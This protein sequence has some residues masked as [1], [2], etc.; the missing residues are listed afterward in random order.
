[1][2][3][4]LI[5]GATSAIAQETARVW[6]EQGHTL[7]LVGRSP[8]KLEAV[9]QDLRV[10]GATVHSRV[11]DLDKIEDHASLI[12]WAFEILIQVDTALIAHGAMP[13]Q[14]R[15]ESDPV[16]FRSMVQTNYVS[17]VSLGNLLARKMQTGGVLA[18]LSSPAGERGKPS[19]FLYGSTK[20]AVTLYLQ[21]LRAQC[22]GSGIRVITLIPG[23]VDS[24]MTSGM[25]KGPLFSTAKAV[26]NGV[27][28]AIEGGADV[29]YIP[30]YWRWI[31]WIIRLIPEGLFK[32]L[33]L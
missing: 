13:E 31:L 10:R 5:L 7:A 28:R 12:D 14:K 30:G 16:L 25:K 23:M 27:A 9:A 17:V 22:F 32:R 1:M 11:F 15:L 2:K 33:S 3:T 4:A 18:V 20:A 29:A 8:E 6:A 24:P 21:G 26:G 19:N